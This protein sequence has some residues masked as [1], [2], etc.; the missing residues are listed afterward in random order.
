MLFYNL[1]TPVTHNGGDEI[2]A[3]Q[4]KETRLPLWP[5][6]RQ[7]R[8]IAQLQHYPHGSRG[9]SQQTNVLAAIERHKLLQSLDTLLVVS[10][11][12][13]PGHLTQELRQ[14][15]SH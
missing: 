12:L 2:T 5:L 14:P 6:T 11:L 1:E 7:E 3:G 8:I 4:R 10:A 15:D 9:E 13:G